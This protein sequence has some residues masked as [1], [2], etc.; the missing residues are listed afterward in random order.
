MFSEVGKALSKSIP[1]LVLDCVRRDSPIDEDDAFRFVFG[2]LSIGA[3]YTLVKFI[4]FF[5]HA[6]ANFF[7][8]AETR[9]RGGPINVEHEGKIGK[10]IAN[11]KSVQLV[12]EPKIELTGGTLVNRGRIKKAIANYP[13]AAPQCRLDFLTYELAAARLKKEQ[14]GF[15]IHAVILFRMLE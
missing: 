10:A 13:F 6:I 8:I 7:S 14:F 11:G 12:D 2:Q 9:L 4:R 15:R 3:D 1:D 5:L